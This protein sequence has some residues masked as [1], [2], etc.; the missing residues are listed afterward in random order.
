MCD[1]YTTLLV[2]TILGGTKKLTHYSHLAEAA[3]DDAANYHSSI[4][5]FINPSKSGTVKAV[6]PW[7]ELQVIPNI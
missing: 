1:G 3:T 5:R 4:I 7:A 6:S 2:G